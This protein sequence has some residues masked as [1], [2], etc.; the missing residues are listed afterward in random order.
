MGRLV[1]FVAL[2]LP[3]LAT[4]QARKPDFSRPHWTSPVEFTSLGSIRELGDGRLIVPD[5]GE[6]E[7]RLL[8]ERGRFLGTIGRRGGG[9]QEFERPIWTIPL[10]GDSTLVV[11]RDQGRFLLI[12]PD[13]RPVG[14]IPWPRI[15]GSGLRN[16]V[17]GN[18]DGRVLFAQDGLPRP[19]LTST[20][21]LRWDQARARLDTV[22]TIRTQGVVRFAARYEGQD[23][24]VTRAL[25]Y[26]EGDAWVAGPGGVIAVI[27]PTTYVVE[28]FLPDGRHM[29]GTPIPFDRVPVTAADRD[30]FLHSES[31]ATQAHLTFP[32]H[33]PAV[34]AFVAFIAP[35]GELW[36]RRLGVAGDSVAT[37]DRIDRQG[38]RIDSI[39]LPPGRELLG[40]GRSL[41]YVVRTDENDVQWLEA[42]R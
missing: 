36:A 30:R 4:A 31:A 25:P 27:H 33:K 1:L 38:R 13:A 8:D 12:G 7:I 6:R 37:F 11:D 40:F 17:Q 5:P 23:V 20:P 39:R 21:L 14:T 42:Y 41:T 29:T 10:P 9:P 26:D 35:S 28:W 22:T 3:S 18:G 19:G 34:S 2:F 15:D 24:H 16:R 32:D